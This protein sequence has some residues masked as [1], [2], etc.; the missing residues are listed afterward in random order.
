MAYS[1]APVLFFGYPVPDCCLNSDD[2]E[3]FFCNDLSRMGLEELVLERNM[4]QHV[5]YCGKLFGVTRPP[6]VNT[7]DGRPKSFYV[8]ARDRISRICHL[9]SA[10]K[11]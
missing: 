10:A 8:W 4:L 3:R 5:M 9:I 6:V 2:A 7:P 11:A 1:M